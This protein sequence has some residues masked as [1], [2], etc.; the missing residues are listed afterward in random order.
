M[1]GKIKNTV[2]KEQLEKHPARYALVELVNVHSKGLVFE[3][4]HRVIFNVNTE[5]ILDEMVEYFK[6]E[7]LEA[8]YQCFGEKIHMQ[9]RFDKLK[10]EDNCHLIGFV[11]KG[12]FGVFT[13]K[14]PKCNLDVG[15]LL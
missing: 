3:P 15:S 12:K 1:L 14:N 6:E 5:T 10:K 7:G 4:I 13:M 8:G 11:M 2:P 9:E